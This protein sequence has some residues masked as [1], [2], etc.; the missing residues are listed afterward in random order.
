MAQRLKTDWILFFTIVVMVCFGLVMVYSASSV[1]AQFKYHSSYY[2]IVRQTLFAV[3][4]FFFLM[5]FKRIDYRRF[6]NA[7][8]AFG[9]LGLVVAALV[10][11]WF[12]DPRRHR[13][14]N[15]AGVGLQPSEFAK[16]ALIVFLA[17]FVS[18]RLHS[19]NNRHTLLPSVAA[20]V[21][22]AGAVV[23][24][25]LGTAAVL[26]ATA[27]IVFYV[28]GLDRRYILFALG[29]GLLLAVP[30]IL[31][32]PYRTARVVA[33]VDP[34]YKLVEKI[35]P[36][37][38]EYLKNA[39]AIR[40]TGYQARQSRIAVG[41][42]GAAGLGLMQGKQKM[43]YLPEAHTDF[44]YAVVGEELGLWGSSAV[45]FGFLVILWRGLRLFFIAPD[46]FGRYLALGITASI[47]V[48]ALINMSV[49]L[50]LAPTKGIPL[51][52]VSY[53]GSSLLSTL[54]SLGLL[55]SVSEHAG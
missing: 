39:S 35:S 14:L 9:P 2:F 5:F 15:V 12:A 25:D 17:W 30:A 28:A 54:I 50:D 37:I 43:F 53:G 33:F 4:A 40:D 32:K 18:R 44:I 26:V 34:E 46:D 48:Q 7:G 6:R 11:V 55:L 45:L 29:A 8:W 52:M 10:V 24:A 41:S 13:W 38:P 47:V 1:M 23:I 16:P 22:L 42:G 27:A 3:P 20:L 31:V 49:V 51:P 21:V 36:K 19:I